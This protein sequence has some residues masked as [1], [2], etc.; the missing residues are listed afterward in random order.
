MNDTQL[1]D[2]WGFTSNAI[3]LI[4]Y[5]APL[6]T[7]FTVIKTRSSASLHLP[8]CIMNTINGVLWLIYG[9]ALKDYFI[10]VPN[11]EQGASTNGAS[12]QR[13]RVGR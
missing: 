13:T 8:L 4:Y 9:L 5:A 7:I 2:M 3:L 10:W 1:K 6:S 12:S 11:G